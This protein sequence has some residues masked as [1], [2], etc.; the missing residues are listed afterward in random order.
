MQ[1]FTY[2][3]SESVCAA[4]PVQGEQQIER[5][6]ELRPSAA[7]RASPGGAAPVRRARAAPGRVLPAAAADF[8]ARARQTGSDRQEDRRGPSARQRELAQQQRQRFQQR[9]A[10]GAR[11]RLLGR[12]KREVNILNTAAE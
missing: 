8:A 11:S 6:R 9:P 10:A 2:L 12:R 7:V 3:T 5:L 4:D 1:Y